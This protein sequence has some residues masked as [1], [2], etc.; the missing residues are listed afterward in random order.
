MTGKIDLSPRAIAAR[1]LADQKRDS[2]TVRELADEI[3]RQRR[4]RDET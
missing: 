1:A 2:Q 3:L 4:D